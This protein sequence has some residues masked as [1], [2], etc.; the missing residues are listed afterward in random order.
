MLMLRIVLMTLAVAVAMPATA[1]EKGTSTME[2]LRQKVQTDKRLLVAANMDLTGP[3]EKAFWPL[4]D[5]YQKDLE[6]IDKRL[7]R[8]IAHYADAYNQGAV[9]NETAKKLL[10]EALAVEEAEV[11]LKR[12][13]VPQLE[14]VLP[15]AK[16]AR[17][18]QLETKIRALVRFEL[19][20]KIP[21]VK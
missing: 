20:D 3:Q 11:A 13:Y 14:Q 5:A 7:A 10:D 19:A 2:I 21:L 8:V 9:S 15:E 6:Q 4:Y 16:V 1:Q 18:L 17:Y 12:S